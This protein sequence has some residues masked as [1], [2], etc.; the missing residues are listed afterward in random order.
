MGLID[1]ARESLAPGASPAPRPTTTP[2]AAVPPWKAGKFAAPPPGVTAADLVA[3]TFD[4]PRFLVEGL[5]AEGLTILAGRPKHGKSWLS[6]LLGWAVAGGFEVDGRPTLQGDVLYLAL[7][8]TRRRLQSR[9]VKLRE[10]TGWFVPETLTLQTAWP[11]A[12]GGGLYHLAEWIE[13]HRA[14]ARLVIVDTIARFRDQPKGSGGA[15]YAEDYTAVGG[16]KELLDH[17]GLSGLFVTHTRK[18]K[19]DDPLDEVSGTLGLTGAADSTWVLDTASKG[20]AARLYVTGRDLPDGTVPLAFAADSGRWT[21]GATTPGHDLNARGAAAPGGPAS[22][23]VEA[24]RA[25]L[26]SFLREYAYPAKEVDAAG[27]AAGH[28]PTTIR[29]AKSQ[30]GRQGTG[31]LW[32]QKVGGDRGEW[33]IGV[34]SPGGWKSRPAEGPPIPE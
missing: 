25:W 10:A 22:G 34:G 13:A 12:G 2:A 9:L 1:K 4:P 19:A 23:R 15:T 16:T 17:Y 8:D 31:E 20:E 21:V 29:D 28:A 3:E 27:R 33:W 30:L 26:R 18:L 14:T 11:R 7:E 5:L 24:C 32:F 6:L